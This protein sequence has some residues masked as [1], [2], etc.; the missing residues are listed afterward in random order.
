M[1]IGGVLEGCNLAL[2]FLGS[3]ERVG[4]HEP[5]HLTCSDILV[6]IVPAPGAFLQGAGH[7]T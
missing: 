5:L 6:F 7:E 3:E 2:D 1:L 4:L